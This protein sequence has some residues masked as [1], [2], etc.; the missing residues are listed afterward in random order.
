MI[1]IE[2]FLEPLQRQRQMQM[3]RQKTK[4]KTQRPPEE[5]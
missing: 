1:E 4:K 2:S 3:Q 5:A